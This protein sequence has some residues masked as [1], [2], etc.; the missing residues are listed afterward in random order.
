MTS[1]KPIRRV[2][3]DHTCRS[4]GLSGLD[5]C[6]MCDKCKH[7]QMRLDGLCGRRPGKLQIEKCE[8]PWNIP[9]GI[10][11]HTPYRLIEKKKHQ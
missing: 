9:N 1:L 5:L 10:T 11:K 2:R 3:K 7:F 4:L 6:D 8:K